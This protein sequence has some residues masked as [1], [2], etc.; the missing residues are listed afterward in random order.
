MS[1]LARIIKSFYHVTGSVNKVTAYIAV[2]C[3][4]AMM[5]LTAADVILR[6]IGKLLSKYFQYYNIQPIT[7]SYELIQFMMVITISLGLAYCGLEKSHVTIDVATS[8]LPRRTRAIIDSVITVLALI[9]TSIVTWQTCLY[10]TM[11]QKSHLASSVLLVPVYP[12]VAIVAFGVAFYTVVL[13]L[14]FL[15]YLKAGMT[16]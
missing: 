2:V 13:I 6:L 12:F 16:K 15:E 11:L 14:H 3:L 10:I 7:G 4:A 8:H 1:V 5:F 9:I